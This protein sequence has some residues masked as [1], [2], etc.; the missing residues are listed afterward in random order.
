MNNAALNAILF[1]AT[2]ALSTGAMGQKVYRCGNNYSHIP[3]PEAVAIDAVD[4]RSKN[5]KQEADRATARA[6]ATANT[7]EKE[8]LKTEAHAWAN[9][10]A[11]AA[12]LK[13]Q[14]AKAEEPANKT[15][16][17]SK[18]QENELFTAAAAPTSKPNGAQKS[19]PA[20]SK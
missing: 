16:T 11:D 2:C 19:Q 12:K 7:L 15:K 3:C 13:K 6:T 20:A 8:R 18:K 9:N 4:A 10:K 5:Q 17:N 1:I 14:T